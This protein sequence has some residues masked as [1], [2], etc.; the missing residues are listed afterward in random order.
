[1]SGDIHLEG[2]GACLRNADSSNFND[3]TSC[4]KGKK[5]EQTRHAYLPMPTGIRCW[6]CFGKNKLGKNIIKEDIP[7]YIVLKKG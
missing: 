1:M 6:F 2:F 7:T 4:K 3:V 5:I